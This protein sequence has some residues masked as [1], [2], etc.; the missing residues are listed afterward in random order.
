MQDVQSTGS[1]TVP[2]TGLEKCQLAANYWWMLAPVAVCPPH[3]FR[4]ESKLK[5]GRL[6]DSLALDMEPNDSL[7]DRSSQA[8]PAGTSEAAM[9]TNPHRVGRPALG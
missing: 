3:E 6:L 1:L 5:P 9:L 4:P 7:N 2:D 8:E